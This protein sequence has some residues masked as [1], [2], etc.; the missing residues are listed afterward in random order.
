MRPCP[1]R[2][3]RRTVDAEPLAGKVVQRDR[4][5]LGERMLRPQRHHQR[6]A[7]EHFPDDARRFLERTAGDCDVD[8]AVGYRSPK[9]W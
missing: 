1:G 2:K 3:K 4:I 7:A 8:R 6:L 5:P 9:V